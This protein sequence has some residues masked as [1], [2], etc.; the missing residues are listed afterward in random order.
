MT[1]EEY[2]KAREDWLA[3]MDYKDKGTLK[4]CRKN[5]RRLKQMY[6]EEKRSNN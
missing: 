4:W 3:I 1:Q 6:K 2:V 5:L